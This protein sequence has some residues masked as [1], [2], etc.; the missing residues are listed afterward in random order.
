MTAETVFK[1]A[2]VYKMYY[3]GRY[4]FKLYKGGMKMPPLIKQPDRRY[5]HRFAQKLNDDQIHALFTLGFFFNPRAHVSDFASPDA[6]KA[7][8]VF[9]SRSENG[10]TLLEHDL[11]A[12]SQRLKTVDID[13]W[14]YGEVLSP[15]NTRAL[16][17]PVLQEVINGELAL[18]TACLILLIPQPS[19]SYHWPAAME[20]RDKACMGLG[21]SE[22]IARL[23]LLDQ[24]LLRQRPG[25]RNLT[26]GLASEFW[27]NLPVTSLAPH[28]VVAES[29]LF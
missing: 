22:W 15:H 13:A 3:Q 8:V 23:K 10:R 18:D 17:P 6:E 12:L 14:L 29:S 19:L 5:Y 24:L 4:D 7:A 26:W 20:P 28:A 9:A 11:Y 25:W 16:M 1:F 27:S 2:R 21:P